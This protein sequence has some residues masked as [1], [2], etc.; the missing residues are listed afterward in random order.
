[1]SEQAFLRYMEENDY[2]DVEVR[3]FKIRDH[4]WY[5]APPDPSNPEGV[6]VQVLLK[7]G[8]HIEDIPPENY[9]HIAMSREERAWWRLKHFFQLQ[10]SEERQQ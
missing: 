1:M 5:R 7:D 6:K 4:V 8:L 3:R 9:T 2:S 10:G